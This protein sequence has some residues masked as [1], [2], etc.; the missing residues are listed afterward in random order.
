MGHPLKNPDS[1]HYRMIGGQE[2][3]EVMEQVFTPFELKIWA[4]ITAFKYRM[5]I[6]NKDE[7]VKEAIKISGYEEYY[8]YLEKLEKK[9]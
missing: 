7:V 4:K 6:G 2:A 8:K 1:D 9:S 5:R 3:V